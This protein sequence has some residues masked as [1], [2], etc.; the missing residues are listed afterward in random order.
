MEA[1]EHI[2][3]DYPNI[4]VIMCTAITDK[5]V[6]DSAIALGASGYVSK[7]FLPETIAASINR[8]PK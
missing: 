2:R 3:N 1:L 8:L 6:V 7:P 5:D 4:K